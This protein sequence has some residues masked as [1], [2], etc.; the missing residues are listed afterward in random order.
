V[1]AAAGGGGA[2]R[3]RS[4]GSL[5]PARPVPPQNQNQ[6]DDDG[7]GKV[8]D[9]GRGE[10]GRRYRALTPARRP[11]PT[12]THEHGG[13]ARADSSAPQRT[14]LGHRMGRPCRL[15]PNGRVDDAHG[16]AGGPKRRPWVGGAVS[17][18][19]PAAAPVAR[20]ARRGYCRVRVREQLRVPCSLWDVVYNGARGRG[21]IAGL[22]RARGARTNAYISKFRRLRVGGRTVWK[23]PRSVKAP[24]CGARA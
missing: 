14:R 8:G 22:C 3:A 7:G 20:R 10:P 5:T 9:G 11:P 4:L 12:P 24:P 15:G 16:H 18:S 17:A 13:R 19:A 2:S 6:G 23:G 21:A 1:R